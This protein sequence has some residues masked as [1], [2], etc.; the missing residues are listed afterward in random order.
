MKLVI[1]Y[2]DFKTPELKYC[3]RGIE[4]YIDDPEIT[5]IGD[6]PA[7]IKNVS[8]IPFKDN[9]QNG[10][11]SR[12][13][14]QKIMLAN[15]DFLFFND[16]HFLLEPFS[17]DTYH[18]SGTI[19]GEL[20][21][22]TENSYL[23]TLKNTFDLY[24]DIKNFDTHCPIFYR[25]EVLEKIDLNWKVNQGYCI[26]SI[27]AMHA[28]IEGTEYPDLKIKTNLIE[29]EI[30][31]LIAG[32]PYFSTGNYCINKDMVIVWESLYCSKSNFEL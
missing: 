17:P 13:I 28:C 18:Y 21:N 14:Y 3:L 10:F 25:R 32:R 16:D 4:K 31:K 15:F 29:A 5:I 11:R 26:K 19:K 9:V 23:R 22:R 24:G 27:Y 30:R 8:H 20:L 12:N 7:W 1:P 6:K 2:R